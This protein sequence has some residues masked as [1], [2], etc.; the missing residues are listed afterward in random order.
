M[1]AAKD[2]IGNLEKAQP[3]KGASIKFSDLSPGTEV[4]YVYTD[5]GNA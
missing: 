3:V 4:K 1:N 2:V 5:K